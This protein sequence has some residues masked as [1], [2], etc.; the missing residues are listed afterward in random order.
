MQ[1]EH[2]YRYYYRNRP[3]PNAPLLVAKKTALDNK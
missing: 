3:H 2:K 1:E